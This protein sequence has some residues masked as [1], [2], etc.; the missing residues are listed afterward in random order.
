MI[1]GSMFAIIIGYLLG[2]FPT[3]YIAGRL[4]KGMDIRELGDGNMGTAN[5]WR[6]LGARAGIAVINARP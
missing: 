4:L 5:A 6:E 3:A 2:S 1:W